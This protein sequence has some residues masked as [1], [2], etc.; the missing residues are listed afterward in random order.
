MAYQPAN[1]CMRRL[2]KVAALDRA[3]KARDVSG[4]E[5]ARTA[6]VSHQMIAELRAGKRAR[7]NREAARR[8]EHALK[9]DEYSLFV[10]ECEPAIVGAGAA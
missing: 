3:M 8:I 1:V 7:V 10:S 2:I 6:K 4:R 5:L 9:V